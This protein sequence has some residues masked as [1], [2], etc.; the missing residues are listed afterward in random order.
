M[1]LNSKSTSAPTA[2][3]S[4]MTGVSNSSAPNATMPPPGQRMLEIERLKRN[5]RSRLSMR[6]KRARPLQST[7]CRQCGV[8]FSDSGTGKGKRYNRVFCG[9]VC[10]K[11]FARLNYGKKHCA[12][13]KLR[14]LP[15]DYTITAIAVFSR[16][17]WRCQLC[18]K[19]TP[20]RLMG[21]SFPT[22]PEIDHIVPLAIKSSP[23]H[24]WA[25]V[26]CACRACNGHKNSKIQ[27]Q[28]RM[29]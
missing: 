7:S 1:T 13:A 17:A 23:G 15:R 10:R 12:R 8:V 2:A 21:L 6:L 4:A 24:V 26:Q 29:F 16:D 18:G 3:S 9:H 20:Q 28:L 14:G 11:R 27:G 22:S 5:E 19:L 25:N